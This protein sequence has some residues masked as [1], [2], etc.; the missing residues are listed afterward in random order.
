M[1]TYARCPGEAITK[2]QHLA[3]QD[4]FQGE[5]PLFEDDSVELAEPPQLPLRGLMVR[6]KILGFS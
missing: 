2:H 1:Y 3:V 4:I 5:K 6:T